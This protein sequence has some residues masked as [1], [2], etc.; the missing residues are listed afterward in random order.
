MINDIKALKP[1]AI[2]GRCGGNEVQG[3]RVMQEKSL[4]SLLFNQL[5]KLKLSGMQ[6]GTHLLPCLNLWNLQ[7][8]QDEDPSIL[9]VN[10]F[11]DHAFHAGEAV[12]T[13]E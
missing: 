10:C 5:S 8:L 11:T 3:E 7:C 6:L 1:Q 9:Q 4:G 13:T 2:I 12:G